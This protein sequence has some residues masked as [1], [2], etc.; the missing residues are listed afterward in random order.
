M[1]P[2]NNPNSSNKED[3]N[4]FKELN[5]GDGGMYQPYA[6]QILVNEEASIAMVLIVS[7]TKGKS[8]SSISIRTDANHLIPKLAKC[9]QD[10]GKAMA[11]MPPP[12]KVGVI[13]VPPPDSFA[14]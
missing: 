9:L 13:P 5:E 3:E 2:K 10:I 7:P 12:T 1:Q 4:I 6:D 8:G 11:E 14:P